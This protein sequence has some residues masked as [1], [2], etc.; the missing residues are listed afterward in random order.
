MVGVPLR[1]FGR[2]GG[3][4]GLSLGGR[5]P[6]A[7]ELARSPSP[8][9]P[10]QWVTHLPSSETKPRAFLASGS[11]GAIASTLLAASRA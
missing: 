3:L 7:V 9:S 10:L 8:C 11:L 2:E 5:H 6:L 4:A 1:P